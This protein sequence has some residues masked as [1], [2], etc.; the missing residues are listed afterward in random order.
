MHFGFSY[1]GL[2]FLLM[3]FIPNLFWTKHRPKG[4]DGYSK[5]ENRVLLMLERIGEIAV[6]GLVLIF[7]DFNPQGLSPWL[8]WLGAA[9]A[10]MAGYEVFWIRYFRSPKTMRD[11][12]SSFL[13]IPVAG[14]T[15]PV[16]SVLCLA[17]YGKNPFL[18]AAG[19][20]LGVGHI[21]IHLMHKKEAE[22]LEPICREHGFT[23]SDD[24]KRTHR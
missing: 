23:G 2:V 22:Q 21:G 9:L 20:L 18:F 13:G 16:L 7:S 19:I 24:L 8:L 4:Y 15:L 1:V 10:C 11:F 14:A 6:S 12:Y 3:L 17:V 5:H